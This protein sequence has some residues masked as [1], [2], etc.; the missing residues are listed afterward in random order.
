MIMD[1]AVLKEAQANF[2]KNDLTIAFLYFFHKVLGNA[3]W[4]FFLEKWP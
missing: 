3:K 4:A 1:S 2:Y